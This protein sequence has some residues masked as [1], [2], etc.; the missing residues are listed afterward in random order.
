MTRQLHPLKRFE[1]ECVADQIL[2]T[3]LDL[4]RLLPIQ[5]LVPGSDF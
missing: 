1:D 4:L 3:P 2:F 5:H